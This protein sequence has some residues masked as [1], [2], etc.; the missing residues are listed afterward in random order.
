MAKG[1]KRRQQYQR[2]LQELRHKIKQ[3]SDAEGPPAES[4]A[5]APAA[6]TSTEI[7][8][9]PGGRGEPIP[10]S[11][12]QEN[13]ILRMA[14]AQRWDIG[15]LEKK[16]G[17]GVTVRNMASPD[18]RISNNAVKNLLGMEKQNMEAE[19]QA[20]GGETVNV[21]HSGAVLLPI[22]FIE[23]APYASPGINGTNG[24]AGAHGP[25]L[26]PAPGPAESNGQ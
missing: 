17:V 26:P 22:E 14:I 2:K 12:V 13:Q 25:N 11:P 1:K 3:S 4:D 16:A 19:K 23:Y 20:A 10:L 6:V 7:P 8:P 15:R 9:V 5:V 21:K 18:G 24:T